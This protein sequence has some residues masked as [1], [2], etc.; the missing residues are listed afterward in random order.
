LRASIALFDQSSGQSVLT[1]ISLTWT[2]T[3]SV[4]QGTSNFHTSAP[5]MRVNG[6]SHGRSRMA[7]ASG[8]IV[9][10]GVTVLLD[11]SA[12]AQIRQSSSGTVVIN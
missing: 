10:N 6:R 3:E 12:F 5:G 1:A 2:A 7:L 11:Q 4:S 8:Q 9:E